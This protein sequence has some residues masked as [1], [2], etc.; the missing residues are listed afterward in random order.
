[1]GMPAGFQPSARRATRSSPSGVEAASRIGGRGR[2]AP[3]PS[4]LGS[5]VRPRTSRASSRRRPAR[6][7]RRQ[8]RPARRA[9]R[10]GRGRSWAGRRSAHRARPATGRAA[11][12][13]TR[14]DDAGPRRTGGHRGGVGQRAQRVEAG[15]AG[16]AAV[17]RSCADRRSRPARRRGGRGGP[18]RVG[19][20]AGLGEETPSLMGG[21]L[22][23]VRRVSR[24][25]CP[26]ALAARLTVACSAVASAGP[27]P[28]LPL[29]VTRR[30]RHDG[31]PCGGR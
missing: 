9:W 19:E 2:P 14:G 23:Q 21:V 4:V 6:R 7:R 22:Q 26:G 3:R 25:L 30:P 12:G 11:P 5:Q 27:G 28:A 10:R 31:P 18:S 16:A 29:A 24:H 1:M 15:V 17:R 8:Q 20:A 13:G